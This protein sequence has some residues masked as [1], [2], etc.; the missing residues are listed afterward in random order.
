M[1]VTQDPQK[2]PPIFPN[3]KVNLIL[4][5]SEKIYI[6]LVVVIALVLLGSIFS[7]FVINWKKVTKFVG[8]FRK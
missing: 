3:V 5:F 1:I 6:F 7:Y 2:D 4:D 8:K